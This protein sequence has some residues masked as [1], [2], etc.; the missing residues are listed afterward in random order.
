VPGRQIVCKAWLT[1]RVPDSLL[2][3]LVRRT[4]MVSGSLLV[5]LKRGL[6]A[7]EQKLLRMLSGE[8]NDASA[9]HVASKQVLGDGPQKV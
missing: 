5:K 2:H 7:E 4:E 3:I 8:A 9:E 1:L 6:H